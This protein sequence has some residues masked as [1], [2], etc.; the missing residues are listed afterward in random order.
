MKKYIAWRSAVSLI[1][2]LIFLTVNSNFAQTNSQND[3]EL[4]QTMN[5]VEQNRYIDALPLLEKVALRY[6]KNAELMAHYGIAVLTNLV[7]LKDADA[8]AG[9]RKRAAE[10]LTKAKELGTRNQIAL[11]YLDGLSDEDSELDSVSSTTS[12]EAEDLIREGEAFFGRG[13]Y[14]KAFVL[15]EKAYKSDPK[16]YEAALFAGDCFYAQKKYAEAETWFAKAVA[17]NPNREQALRFWGDALLGQGKPKEALLKFADAV[18]AEPN[19]R[20]AWSQL[21]KWIRE[22]GS[23]KTSAI[24]YPPSNKDKVS[25][26]IE[27][28]SALLK[29]DD[30]TINWKKYSGDPNTR[31]G[32]MSSDGMTFTLIHP[33]IDADIKA[34]EAVVAGVKADTK[35]GKIKTLHNGLVNLVQLDEMKLIDVYVLMVM[36]GG[37]K[38][39]EFKEFREKNRE[40]MRQFF[41]EYFVASIP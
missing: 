29:A 27:V 9:E 15:Y 14:D 34:L 2:L 7:T 38:C 12:K 18:I 16:S 13:E 10:I 26:F 28:D 5:L 40:R 19:S 37:D 8:K 24:V 22:N 1:V 23:R 21:T 41:V 6:P 36:H 33:P 35:A 17:I 25:S 39:H 20:L 11:H 31:R 32:K 30:G 4:M 3:E